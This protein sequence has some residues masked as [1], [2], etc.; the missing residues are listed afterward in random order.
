MGVC[1][2]FIVL[3]FLAALLAVLAACLPRPDEPVEWVRRPESIVV[4]VKALHDPASELEQRVVVPEFTLYGDGTLIFTRPDDEG[5]PRLLRAQL[6][7]EAIRDLLEFVVEKGFLE[8]FY[9]QPGPASGAN[10][11]ATFIYVNTIGGANS[12]RALGLGALSLE[13]SGEEFDDLRRLEEI[14]RRL[15]SL[16]PEAVGGEIEGEFSPE[17][18]LLL[19][20]PTGASNVVGSPA[21]WPFTTIDLSEIAP[22]DSTGGERVVEGETVSDLMNLLPPGPPF[23]LAVKQGER[24]FEVSYRF[25]LP[26]EENFPE[27]DQP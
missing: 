22:P 8:F 18:L 5:P 26:F 16:D 21:V 2:G 19:V 12:V 15:N 24:T 7:V 4:Q 6:P 25:L 3:P 17:A 11:P 14:V 23:A 1:K 20:Q 9:D 13:D 27:F 10:L